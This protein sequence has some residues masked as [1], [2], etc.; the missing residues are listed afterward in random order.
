[1]FCYVVPLCWRFQPDVALKY[2]IP[3]IYVF[4]PYSTLSDI[5]LVLSLLPIYEAG[6]RQFFGLLGMCSIVDVFEYKIQYFLHHFYY[7]RLCGT[8]GQT[9]WQVM[10]IFTLRLRWRL[11]S[12][13][14]C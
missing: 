10:L 6:R 2:L 14:K 11:L 12:G 8:Y 1:M 13:G 9:Q 3:L 7:V 4:S 5:A